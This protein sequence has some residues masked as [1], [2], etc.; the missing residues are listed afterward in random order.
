MKKKSDTT[1]APEVIVL[2]DENRV[3]SCPKSPT[4]QHEWTKLASGS[5]CKIFR[6]PHCT[7][8]QVH[9]KNRRPEYY[10][11]SHRKA[12]VAATSN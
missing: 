2:S 1:A 8:M 11:S 9:W 12:A 5:E 7:Q 4:G 6:C 10:H 3:P